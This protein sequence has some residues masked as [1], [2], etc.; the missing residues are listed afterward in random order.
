M[1]PPCP[2]LLETSVPVE[3]PTDPVRVRRV[4]FTSS[5]YAAQDI[6]Y[7]CATGKLPW[8]ADSG[9]ALDAAHEWRCEAYKQ[10]AE[11]YLPEI[12]AFG[13]QTGLNTTK[14]LS[15]CTVAAETQQDGGGGKDLAT[16]LQESLLNDC[17][18]AVEE[19]LLTIQCV[20]SAPYKMDLP[21]AWSRIVTLRRE[22]PLPL[23]HMDLPLLG[24]APPHGPLP[25]R[26]QVG[27]PH[28]PSGAADQREGDGGDPAP[29]QQH[30]LTQDAAAR[31]D[32]Y[33]GGLH[34]AKAPRQG[35][36]APLRPEPDRSDQPPV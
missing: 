33:V 2:S 3:P 22:L 23:T 15:F 10:A 11:L 35:G 27:Q 5:G 18:N 9:L 29:Q 12:L 1:Y 24:L 26:L 17:P 4:F 28:H 30:P 7:Y 8:N 14:Q 21:D 13:K 16:A 6:A 36:Q 25:L 32:R 20:Q 34:A 31:L 19:A